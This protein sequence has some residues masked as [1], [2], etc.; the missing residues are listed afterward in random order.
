MPTEHHRRPTSSD[1]LLRR[2]CALLD[3]TRSSGPPAGPYGEDLLRRWS[4]PHR[5][6]HTV[7]HLDAVLHEVDALAG[8][9]ADP[10]AVRLAA[11]FHDAVYRPEHSENEAASARL[12][13]RALG[14]AGVPGRRAD[15]VSRLVL[16]TRTH[17][18]EAGDRDGEVLC[19]A[20]LAVLAGSPQDYAAYAAAVRE[21]YS[22]VPDPDFR[23]GRA[24]VLRDLLDLP[25]LYR[26]PPARQRYAERARLNLSTELEL[27][28]AGSP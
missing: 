8:Y 3:R 15:E 23:A 17:E 18:P 25:A 6:Y 22:F 14:E 4:E 9:A 28:L 13:L 5:R 7:A 24:A 19:D 21:E 1:E 27:L 26:T 11:W 16:L 20:D 12:A 2:W 10:D